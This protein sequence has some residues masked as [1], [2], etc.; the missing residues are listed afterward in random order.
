MGK[1]MYLLNLIFLTRKKEVGDNNGWR[2]I[3]RVGWGDV[4]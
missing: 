2:I 1:V 3:V 4:L